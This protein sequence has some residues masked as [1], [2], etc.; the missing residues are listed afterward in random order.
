ME[1]NDNFERVGNWISNSVMLKLVTITFL[2]LVL[3]VPSLMVMSIIE[4]RESMSKTAQ[5]EVGLKWAGYQTIGGPIVVV[6]VQYTEKTVLDGKEA[7]KSYAKHLKILPVDFKIDGDIIPKTLRRGIFEIVVYESNLDVSGQFNFEGIELTDHLIDRI[8]WEKARMIIGVSD[9]RGISSDINLTIDGRSA[10]V[11]PGIG[12]IKMNGGGVSAPIQLGDLEKKE[13]TFH[14][15]LQLQ[16]SKNLSFLPVG[17]RTSV[18]FKSSWPSPSFQGNFLPKTREVGD[19]GFEASWQIL[20][21]NRDF[22]KYW[23]GNTYDE[24]LLNS[25]SGTDL[26]MPIDD[27]QKSM[28]SAK[29]AIM[30]IGLTFL[31][32]FIIE[33]LNRRKI[34]PFQ[35]VLVGLALVIFYLLLV[36]LSEQLSFNLAYLISATAIIGVITMY[37]SAIFKKKK[38]VLLLASVMAALYGF[39]FVTLQLADFALLLGSIGML[40]ILSLVM[41]FTKNINWYAM[42]FKTPESDQM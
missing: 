16:G 23:I 34:H 15:K 6:P 24:S 14:F 22:P 32:F 33:M 17:S 27:Y 20:E 18:T 3:W 9:L 4:E 40:V 42:S 25:E 39:V 35:Y 41:Y 2:I 13:M 12:D 1:T 7:S 5:E 26:L 21:L 31:I 11:E 19:E 8:M 28:R 30:T 37:S 38:Q 29:Y 36:S 10:T